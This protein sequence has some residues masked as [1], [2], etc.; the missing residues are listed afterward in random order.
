M[1]MTIYGS[2][3]CASCKS[4][5]MAALALNIDLT[6]ITIDDNRESYAK[7]R[8]FADEQF[9]EGTQVTL[10]VT[11]LDDGN[12]QEVSVGF[13]P[14]MALLRKAREAQA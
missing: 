1:K 4:L 6:Y 12:L 10:P 8:K 5:R 2:T 7:F 9:G 3:S 11:L 13:M 14:G